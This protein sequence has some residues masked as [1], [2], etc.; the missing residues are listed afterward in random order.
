MC[1]DEGYYKDITVLDNPQEVSLGDGR[2]L[3]ATAEG[4]VSL[5][6]L[7]T[8][9][10]K[11]ICNLGNVLLIPKLA[12]NLLSISKVSDAGKTVKFDDEKCEISN[13]RGECIAIGSFT[14]GES[15]LLAVRQTTAAASECGDKRK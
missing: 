14:N 9:G 6:M 2:V 12:Y 1:N 5:Q 7:L 3:K 11:K 13:S 15:I 4:T 10:T 8:D